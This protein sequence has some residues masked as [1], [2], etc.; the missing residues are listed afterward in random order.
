MHPKWVP[1][2]KNY[3]GKHCHGPNEVLQFEVMLHL[4]LSRGEICVPNFRP[5]AIFM[6]SNVVAKPLS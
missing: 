1:T 6:T 2:L 4:K 5:S 3:Y